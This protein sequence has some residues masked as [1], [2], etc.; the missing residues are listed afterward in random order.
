MSL[1]RWC[2]VLDFLQTVLRDYWHRFQGSTT[3]S[4]SGELQSLRKLHSLP[5]RWCRKYLVSTI[6][7]QNEYLKVYMHLSQPLSHGQVSTLSCAFRKTS[8]PAMFWKL[9][10]ISW[11]WHA[12]C[13]QMPGRTRYLSETH[14]RIL[15]YTTTWVDWWYNR[16]WTHLAGRLRRDSLSVYSF[17]AALHSVRKSG[18]RAKQFIHACA[19]EWMAS[20]GNTLFPLSNSITSF[21]TSNQTPVTCLSYGGVSMSTVSSI[22]PFLKYNWQLANY[23]L[24]F[25]APDLQEACHHNVSNEPFTLRLNIPNTTVVISTPVQAVNDC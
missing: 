23:R 20:A 14:R 11:E 9:K 4:G 2:P 24:T 12:Y 17:S 25:N 15:T 16:K 13:D 19:A 10:I 7:K 8:P 5:S 3:P 21:G 18:E 22:F 6:S 1:Q